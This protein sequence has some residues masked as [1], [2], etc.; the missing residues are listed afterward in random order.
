VTVDEIMKVVDSGYPDGA[1]GLHYKALRKGHQH[2]SRQAGD[3]LAL[4]VATELKE[5]QDELDKDADGGE[6]SS[7]ERLYDA[8]QKMEV[9]VQDIEGVLRALRTKLTGTGEAI[10]CK[11]CGNEA[12]SKTA[13]A[14]QGGHVGECCWD[15]RLKNTE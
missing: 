13:H 8:I 3:T 5:T 4:A 15:E 14:H 2:G 1:V 6:V 11:L 7:G 12:L 9:F 10:T